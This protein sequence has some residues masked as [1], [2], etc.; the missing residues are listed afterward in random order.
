MIGQSLRGAL[1]TVAAL[2]LI[3]CG[4][5]H[6]AVQAGRAGAPVDTAVLTDASVA[7][8]DTQ[9]GATIFATNCATCHGATGVEGGVGPSLRDERVRKSYDATIAWI[10]NPQPPM[11]RLFPSPL[12]DIEVR[13][14]AAYVQSL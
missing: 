8:G 6:A 5:G 9:N 14:V 10:K 3:G 13:D 1:A 7:A 11:P 2:V 12:T 4:G